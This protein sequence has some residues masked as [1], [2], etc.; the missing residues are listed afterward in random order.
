MKKLALCFVLALALVLVLCPAASAED[1]VLGTIN[2]G[3]SVNLL[4]NIV[5]TE[6]FNISPAGDPGLWIS[7][8]YTNAGIGLYLKGTASAPGNYM[9]TYLDAAGNTSTYYYTVVAAAAP[10]P[11]GQPGFS[12]AGVPVVMG[13]ADVNCQMGDRALLSAAASVNDGGYLSYQWHSV[14][15]RV[16]YGGSPIPGANGPEYVADTS[17]VGTVY[18]YCLVTN[19]L[20]GMQSSASTNAIAVTVSAPQLQHVL[21]NTPPNKTNYLLGDGL[22]TTGLS[23]I[24]YTSNGDQMIVYEGFTC[25]PTVFDREGQYNVQVSYQGF[26][27]TFPVTVAK[28]EAIVQQMSIASYPNKTSYMKGERLD[29]AGLVCRVFYSDGTQEDINFGFSCSP[30]VLSSTGSQ[31]ITVSF[32]NKTATFNVNVMETEK[33]LEVTSTPAKLSYTVG[34]SLNT[35]GLVL[36]LTDGSST[37]IVRSGFTCEPSVLNTVGSQTVTVRYNGQTTSFTVSVKAAAATPTP[38][39]GSGTSD[40][41]SDG[42]DAD[43]SKPSGSN[44]SRDKL[45]QFKSNRNSSSKR[46]MLWIVLVLCVITLIGLGAYM[47]YMKNSSR[48]RR[49]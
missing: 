24:A 2:Q 13:S 1:V 22:D 37:Q 36:R 29:T 21:V 41:P 25:T 14:H 42:D 10:V 31:T 28:Q 47:V 9:I 3:E 20:N 39:T 5:G 34:E 46:T 19:N 44:D 11:G 38:G 35:A 7:Q 26:S 16:N 48:G 6:S 23:L 18:Y 30:M 15:S 12:Q 8:E 49:Y 45:E 40:S 17:N 32:K 33:K 43:S 4:L 27:T